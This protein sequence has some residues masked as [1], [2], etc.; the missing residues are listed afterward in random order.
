MEDPN[1]LLKVIIKGHWVNNEEIV[2]DK[3]EKPCHILEWCPYGIL[4]EAYP[5]NVLQEE[6][7][8]KHNRYCKLVKGRG[9][10]RCGKNDSQ[11]QPDLN[12]ASVE[13]EKKEIIDPF[14]C[15]FFGHYCPVFYLKENHRE[16]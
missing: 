2:D 9:W 6:Y 4:V 15:N 14:Q 16:F 1:E 8:I 5:L 7:A 13:M 10:V 3:A 11:S 12:W